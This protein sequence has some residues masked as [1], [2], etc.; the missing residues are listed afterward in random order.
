[1]LL[2]S[3]TLQVQGTFYYAI[4]WCV[5]LRVEYEISDFQEYL[6]VLYILPIV[7]QLP[8]TRIAC[9]MINIGEK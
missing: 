2:A 1:M 7:V 9:T 3:P 5:V 8:G 4:H 6:L